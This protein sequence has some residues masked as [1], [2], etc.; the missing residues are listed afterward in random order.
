LENIPRL[1]RR[2]PAHRS[3][4]SNG[5]KLLPLA[6]GRSVTA[7]RF[8]DLIEEISADLGGP[9]ILSE[10]QRQLIRRAAM[11]SA[12]CERLEALAARGECPEF[13]ETYGPLCDRLG[14]LF[15]RLGLKRIA[16]PVTDETALAA[17]FS[18]PVPRAG[19]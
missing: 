6:D 18:R 7:R 11:L 19:E 12:E 17:Y 8:R 10:G 14:R 13:V 3:R 9:S 1:A 16:K 5:S 2:S 15:D 4:V